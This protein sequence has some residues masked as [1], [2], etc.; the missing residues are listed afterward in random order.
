MYTSKDCAFKM[1]VNL[2]IVD[3]KCMY[4][5]RIVYLKYIKNTIKMVKNISY[6]KCM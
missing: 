4:Q 1:H 3:F 2:K 6:L 5:I